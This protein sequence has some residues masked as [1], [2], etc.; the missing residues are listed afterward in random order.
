M[1]KLFFKACI[2]LA[3]CT[4]MMGCN[5]E[6]KSTG[7]YTISGNVPSSVA[8]DW[9]YLYTFKGDDAVVVDSTKIENTAF[10]FK[11][12]VPDTTSFLVLHPGNMNEYPA[13]GWNLFL[14]NG[15]IIVDSAE[16][17]VSGTPL[18]DGLKD[19][20]GSLYN[21]MRMGDPMLVHDFLA[22]HWSEHSG[23]F[24]GSFVLYNFSPFLDFPFVDSLASDVPESVK[25][26]AMLKPFFEQLDQMRA[27]QPGNMFTD[28]DLTYIDGKAVKLSEIIGKGDWVLIDF[29]ASWC[30][31]CRQ[32]MPQLQSTVKK[33][34]KLKV[35]GIAVSEN[36]IE[37][38]QRAIADLKITWPV[39]ND[40]EAISAKAYGVNA[41]PAMILFA[42]DGKI[43]ARDFTVSSLESM[44][45]EKMVK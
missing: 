26:E 17:F 41:I 32:A 28:V 18:N 34:K 36:K 1:K 24:I 6:K 21:I 27:M 22:E 3:A 5:G 15:Q 13:V 39:M 16:Q 29:W 7:R 37:D 35:Y 19:W 9:I 45:E 4:M 11:G 43:A 25:S 14:E 8:A 12:K 10:T 33:F 2:V 38:A 30:G 23:D 44:L 31:P 20:M 40:P 42:P